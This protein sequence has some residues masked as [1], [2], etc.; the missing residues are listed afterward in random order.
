MH[1]TAEFSPSRVAL[2]EAT[3]ALL[4]RPFYPAWQDGDGEGAM[5]SAACSL[6]RMRARMVRGVVLR[7]QNRSQSHE[8]GEL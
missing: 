3:R 1:H 6:P 4:A 5:F 2:R 7:G 8:T